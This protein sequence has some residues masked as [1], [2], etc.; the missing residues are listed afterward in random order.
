[1]GR[2]W[3]IYFVD[4]SL[5]LSSTHFFRKWFNCLD[6]LVVA[7]TFILAIVDVVEIND[8]ARS[9]KY[10]VDFFVSITW[11]WTSGRMFLTSHGLSQSW[12]VFGYHPF[13][14]SY[15][16]HSA[17]HGKAA[18]G[19]RR[20]SVYFSKQAK[21]PLLSSVWLSRREFYRYVSDFS[22]TS[23]TVSTWTLLTSQNVS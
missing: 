2:S 19:N 16:P 17:R 1:M 12:Q 14:P 7:I 6:I 5:I 18:S 9:I 20:S 23:K 15:P 10:V 22:G 13:G 3:I 11:T 21:V 4:I 8:V